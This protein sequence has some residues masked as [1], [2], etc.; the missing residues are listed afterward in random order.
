MTQTSYARLIIQHF[1]AAKNDGTIDGSELAR[2]IALAGDAAGTEQEATAKAAL[3][4]CLETNSDFMDAAALDASDTYL[5][6]GFSTVSSEV[7][8]A[9]AAA[10]DDRNGGGLTGEELQDAEAEIAAVY[11]PEKARDVM[12]E[13]LTGLSD[14]LT[15]DGARWL[16]GGYG[17]L[18]GHVERY[19]A[20]LDEHLKGAVLLDA[21]F[22]GKLEHTDKIVLEKDG[23]TQVVELGENARNKLAIS[24]ALV[25]ASHDMAQAGHSFAGFEQTTFSER[26]WEPN[27]E[28]ATFELKE[29]VSPSEAVQDIFANPGNYQFECATAIVITQYKAMLDSLGPQTFDQICGDLKIG[30]WKNEGH[31]EDARLHLGDSGGRAS[32]Q[33]AAGLKPG[34]Y[35]Y[36]KNWAFRRKVAPQAGKAKT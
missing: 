26:Y 13:A 31:L 10:L 27:G 28:N 8:Q 33:F 32:P 17:A 20:V 6:S 22:D 36:F 3:K 24:T 1:S 4:R 21:D 19:Q 15:V 18:D 12:R 7:K 29:G 16:Q 23:E 25:N 11:G 14:E 35:T 5:R 30:P 34:D 9:M 2:G